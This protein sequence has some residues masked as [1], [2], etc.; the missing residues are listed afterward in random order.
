MSVDEAYK[1]FIGH[2]LSY[3]EDFTLMGGQ[4][5]AFYFP[6]IDQYLRELRAAVP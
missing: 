4:A 3:Q 6:V 2:P 5:F 1:K